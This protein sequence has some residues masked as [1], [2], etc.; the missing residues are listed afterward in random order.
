LPLRGRLPAVP[1]R[2]ECLDADCGHLIVAAD[3]A[4]LIAAVQAH[5]SD[6]HDSFELEDVI[7]DASTEVDDAGEES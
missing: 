3:Q 6:R 4:A 1:L 7:V 5:M 2:Y